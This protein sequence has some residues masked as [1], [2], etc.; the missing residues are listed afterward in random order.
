MLVHQHP[1][2]SWHRGASSHRSTLN[3]SSSTPNSSFFSNTAMQK[4]PGLQHLISLLSTSS[5]PTS[6]YP[7]NPQVQG[8][9]CQAFRCQFQPIITLRHRSAPQYCL[10]FPYTMVSLQTVG[11]IYKTERDS[12]QVLDGMAKLDSSN[13]IRS[14]CTEI[15]FVQLPTTPKGTVCGI[16]KMRK[17]PTV[18]YAFPCSPDNVR[19]TGILFTAVKRM[20]HPH[21]PVV[22]RFL[23]HNRDATGNSDVFV[24]RA[25]LSLP[26]G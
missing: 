17:R 1:Q 9:A 23:F 24:T 3:P 4:R 14:Q 22:P 18:W 12:F 20:S 8:G 10:L 7:D 16:M 2:R 26:T 13:T 19:L 11:G 21:L 25:L 15:R 6:L 5:D